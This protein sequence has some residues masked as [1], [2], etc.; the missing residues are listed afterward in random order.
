VIVEIYQIK[1]FVA[2]V[3]TGSFTRGAARVAVS[4]PALSA[5][6]AKLEQE[7]GVTLLD[8]TRNAVVPTPAGRRLYTVGSAMLQTYNSLKA[9]IRA[10]AAPRALR[11]GIVRTLPTTRIA[12]L[13]HAFGQAYPE[14]IIKLVDAPACDLASR[15]QQKKLDVCLTILRDGDDIKRSLALFEEQ[16]VAI[17]NKAH[18]FAALPTI[19]LENLQNEPFIV[20]TSC[21]TYES[22]TKTLL[23]RGIKTHVVYRTDQDDR[24]LGLVAAGV[25][26][27]LMPASFCNGEVVGVPV[28]DFANRRTIGVQWDVDSPHPEID[29]FISF[30]KSH[31][32][33]VE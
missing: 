6:V 16:Y 14:I 15:L 28:I 33:T 22:A 19:T 26:L 8:R 25:G 9:D 18:R 13:L 5:T 11:V 12:S 20:R 27:A 30:A 3:D 4:Q 17:V 10:V 21:E 7:F 2:I 32:W 1:Q 31:R 23:S 24:V 29:S